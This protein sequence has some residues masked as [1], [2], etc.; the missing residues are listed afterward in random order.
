MFILKLCVCVKANRESASRLVLAHFYCMEH[1]I[2]T[3]WLCKCNVHQKYQRTLNTHK[4]SGILSVNDV[5]KDLIFLY[6]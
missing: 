3:V 6:G 5:I 4:H 1:I 2:N